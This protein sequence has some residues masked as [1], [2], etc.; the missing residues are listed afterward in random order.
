MRKPLA[1]AALLLSAC[2]P[3]PQ[4]V[5]VPPPACPAE[6]MAGCEP[7]LLDPPD[8]TLGQT[9]AT[10]ATN[11]ARWLRCIERDKAKRECLCALER[12]GVTMRSGGCGG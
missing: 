8:P 1:L 7:A 11:R 10:D 2:A 4:R 3:V 6:A 5:D 12:E 9:E